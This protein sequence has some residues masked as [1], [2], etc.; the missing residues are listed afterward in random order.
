[1]LD[2]HSVIDFCCGVKSP[3]DHTHL[4]KRYLLSQ[5]F[6]KCGFATIKPQSIQKWVERKQIPGDRLIELM[7]I[8]EKQGKKLDLYPF[9]LRRKPKTHF[10]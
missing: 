9:I 3:E 6:V 2:V 5:Q 4:E 7:L 10:G 1:M 8:A